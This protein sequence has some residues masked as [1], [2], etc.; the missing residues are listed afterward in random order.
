MRLIV[1]RWLKQGLWAET[2]DQ[3]LSSP[4]E[5]YSSVEETQEPTVFHKQT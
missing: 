5:E 4:L 1:M 3:R 2:P